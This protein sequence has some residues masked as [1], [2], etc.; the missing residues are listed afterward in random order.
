MEN[1]QK[2]L[3]EQELI[4]ATEE[5]IETVKIENIE[6]L[7]GVPIED[8]PFGDIFGNSYR[9]IEPLMSF[10]KGSDVGKIVKMLSGLGWEV[11]L[12][13]DIKYDKENRVV[14]GKLPCSKTKISHYI[15][16]KG[17]QGVSRVTTTLDITKCITGILR[18]IDSGYKELE[19]LYI[20]TST[21][22]EKEV[23]SGGQD[24]PSFR[25]SLN[26]RI[27]MKA[28]K[29]S[30]NTYRSIM[31]VFDAA[32]HWLGLDVEEVL[33]YPVAKLRAHLDAKGV[34]PNEMLQFKNIKLDS[35][36]ERYSLIGDFEAQMD[37]HYVIYSR[38]PIDVYRM[39][40]F[41]GLGSCHTP[42]EMPFYG[43]SWKDR[44]YNQHN[45]CALAEAHGNGMIA[46]AVPAKE[47]KDFPPTQESMDKLKDEEIFY[48]QHRPSAPGRL[49]P[50]ARIR[51]KNVAHHDQET[52]EA[53]GIAVPST[54]IYGAKLSGF[55]DLVM[56]KF[57]NLQKSKIKKIT[58]GSET[59]NAKLFTRYGGDW[60]DDGHHVIDAL[61][62]LFK[63]AGIST[64]LSG[65]SVNYDQLFQNSLMMKYRR[66]RTN[67][68]D[69]RDQLIDIFDMDH[70][71]VKFHFKT[72][73]EP[74]GE[75]WFEWSVFIEYTFRLPA[76]GDGGQVAFNRIKDDI[77]K[78]FNVYQ[79]K[80]STL[81]K[82]LVQSNY[83]SSRNEVKLIFKYNNDD[84]GDDDDYIGNL[85]ILEEM[86]ADIDDN[87]Y[88]LY[89]ISNSGVKI[90]D[91]LFD[92]LVKRGFLPAGA[93]LLLQ[94][95]ISKYQLD[96]GKSHWPIVEK[97]LGKN[98][99]GESYIVSATFEASS[100]LNIESLLKQFGESNKE[101]VYG[102]A[103]NILNTVFASKRFASRLA[104]DTKEWNSEKDPEIM[105]L[106]DDAGK[107]MVRARDLAQNV[108]VKMKI[109]L[110]NDQSK[111]HLIRS[112]K[113]LVSKNS[114][115][116]KVL[117]RV[118]ALVR[119]F[120]TQSVKAMQLSESKKRIKIRVRR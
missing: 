25:Y 31:R 75:V 8:Y 18:F 38:H 116:D 11:G 118:R 69:L 17:K 30:K 46:Y 4:E 108:P 43:A 51:I 104:L 32:N 99:D 73:M 28:K 29:V 6:T 120:V 53:T 67:E 39:S 57:A 1:W 86:L 106:L 97:E 14:G 119:E 96:S 56:N 101:L 88:R 115:V 50:S 34:N 33:K 58:A 44:R 41:Q 113:Y 21:S 19:D 79:T 47:F 111:E 82:S 7:K 77:G 112:A 109:S 52:K 59:I 20:K 9:I 61:P 63:A 48:D 26:S 98:G 64:A 27:P 24:N 40:D 91:V 65:G 49:N 12:P 13:T 55:K 100:D 54:I 93:N 81:P 5:Q 16:G 45:I 66:P 68:D 62:K 89:D 107:T 10:K 36:G 37:K 78:A 15:D 110:H 76:A 92:I 42:P 87:I 60:Q 71:P 94:S 74:D 103:V 23:L 3:L 72:H 35:P 85:E 117:E 102:S 22:H 84:F 114:K 2:F 80:N 90:R 105:I 83:S 95:V 70:G